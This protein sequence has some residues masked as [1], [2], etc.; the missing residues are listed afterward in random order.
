MGTKLV[1][2]VETNMGSNGY[3]CIRDGR[4][5]LIVHAEGCPMG[6][7]RNLAAESTGVSI[8]EQ[9]QRDIHDLYSKLRAAEAKLVGPDGKT[10]V[11][12]GSLYS[13]LCQ[14]LADLKD[15][16]SVTILQS[17]ATLTTMEAAKILGVS[18]QFLVQET[19]KKRIPHHMVGT[20]RRLYARD[21]FAYKSSRDAGRRKQ[22]DDLALAEYEDGL[23]SRGLDDPHSRQ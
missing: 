9:D 20:H 17:E 21:V 10:Q 1:M 22:L 19:T 6:D 2:P 18:R 5:R 4:R 23:Y 13:F 8:T 12:P 11:L 15:G 14:L 7:E 16:K 3:G